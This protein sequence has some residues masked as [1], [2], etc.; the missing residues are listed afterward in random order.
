MLSYSGL[1]R[2]WS[3]GFRVPGFEG[4]IRSREYSSLRFE[5]LDLRAEDLDSRAHPYLGGLLAK[6]Q[7]LAD[8]PE[9]CGGEHVALLGEDAPEVVRSP[10]KLAAIDREREAH[11]RLLGV[12]PLLAGILTVSGAGDD[13]HARTSEFAA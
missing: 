11:V 2:T 7:N 10:L 12:H 3:L 9:E 8:H 1:S 13:E 5:G 6:A 4:H